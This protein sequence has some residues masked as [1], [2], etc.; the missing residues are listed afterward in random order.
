MKIQLNSGYIDIDKIS[1]ISSI[2]S[3]THL[4]GWF[5]FYVIVDTERLE[6]SY[7]NEGSAQDDFA[8]IFK[9]WM[10]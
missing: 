9:L 8:K 10:K 4:F 5:Y 6:F 7:K 3:L 1:Y 2:K